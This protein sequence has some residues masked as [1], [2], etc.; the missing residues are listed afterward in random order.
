M[1]KK[2]LLLSAANVIVV[3][4]SSPALALDPMGP[5]VAGL[6][7]GQWSVGGEYS[8]SSM[9]LQAVHGRYSDIAPEGVSPFYM[10]DVEMDK[11]Y[12]NIGYGV[13]DKWEAFLRLGMV[14]GVDGEIGG[15][16]GDPYPGDFES[17]SDTAIGLG[18]KVTFFT[19]TDNNV[20]WGGLAQI[21]WVEVDGSF[22]LPTYTLTGD[23]DTEIIEAQLA[24]G[25][26]VE[27]TDDI[28]VY[29]GPFLH[30]VDGKY[31]TCDDDGY[32][33][34]Y[35]LEDRSYFGGYAGAQVDVADNMVLN[36][37]YMYTD[38]ADGIGA[39]IICKF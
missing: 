26:T 13:H 5:P 7:K 18:T 6:D 17:G 16:I 38:D 33:A 25:P 36:L 20:T 14:G 22:M 27:V 21:S 35:D 32:E 2:L 19:D 28:R 1:R 10:S 34:I 29:G 8:M 31:E 24:V 37:E 23:H 15:I 30:F 11:Y 9:D 39:S 12:L 4:C 3:L